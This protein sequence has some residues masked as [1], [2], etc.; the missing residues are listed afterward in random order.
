MSG[1]MICILETGSQTP[2]RWPNVLNAIFEIPDGRVPTAPE[3]SLLR[4]LRN[5]TINKDTWKKR[6]AFP[7]CQV[8][9]NFVI[10]VSRSAFGKAGITCSFLQCFLKK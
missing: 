7:D 6:A 8:K 10:E 9:Y 4:I 3:M 1:T 5:R 2:N